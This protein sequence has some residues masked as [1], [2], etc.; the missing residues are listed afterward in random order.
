MASSI[1]GTS[2]V[3]LIQRSTKTWY[4][5]V[6]EIQKVNQNDLQSYL[7]IQDC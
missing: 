2:D 5:S 3:Q 4:N 7:R 1:M 6:I